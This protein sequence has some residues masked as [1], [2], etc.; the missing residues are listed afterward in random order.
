M[1]RFV[2][3]NA[4]QAMLL[5]ILLVLPRLVESILTPPTSGPGLQMYAHSQ[6]FVWIFITVWVVFGIVSSLM[7][8]WAR[9]PFIADAAEQQIR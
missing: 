9:I 6:S 4:M 5:D 7:G 2:R 8:N 3:F 1:S